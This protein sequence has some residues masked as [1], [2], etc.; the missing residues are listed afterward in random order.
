MPQYLAVIRPFTPR[1]WLLVLV[2]VCA[3]API[4]MLFRW[5]IFAYWFILLTHIETIAIVL[6]LIRLDGFS[7]TDLKIPKYIALIDRPFNRRGIFKESVG[8]LF[9]I[10]GKVSSFHHIILIF[11]FEISPLWN[12]KYYFQIPSG[13]SKLLI[14]GYLDNHLFL[15]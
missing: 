15:T 6:I 11:F 3:T 9:G 8:S 2:T 12:C 1:I 4:M 5:A 10:F 14:P 7:W 13:L